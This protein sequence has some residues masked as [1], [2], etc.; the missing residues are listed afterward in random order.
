MLFNTLIVILS[1]INI[2]INLYVDI[3]LFKIYQKKS[4]E[5]VNCTVVLNSNIAIKTHATVFKSKHLM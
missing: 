1:N 5:M 3:E 4:T 2:Y